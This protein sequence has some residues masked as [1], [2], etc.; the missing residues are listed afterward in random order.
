M[1]PV[2][3]VSAPSPEQVCA[4]WAEAFAPPHEGHE[5][6]L[7]T[8]L[9]GLP[10]IAAGRVHDEAGQA[11]TLAQVAERAADHEPAAR[12]EAEVRRGAERRPFLAELARR[13]LALGHLREPYPEEDHLLCPRRTRIDPACA[14][15]PLALARAV[16]AVELQQAELLAE[17]TARHLRWHAH[18]GGQEPAL[19]WLGA[20]LQDDTAQ[21]LLVTA[22]AAGQ[23]G[24]DGHEAKELFRLLVAHYEAC[25]ERAGGS[26]PEWPAGPLTAGCAL[27]L[28]L[29]RPREA[30]LLAEF[31]GHV[32]G[33]PGWQD[34]GRWPTRHPGTDLADLKAR[35]TDRAAAALGLGQRKPWPRAA[36]A[37]QVETCWPPLLAF[38]S[39]AP[40][41]PAR[42]QRD[43]PHP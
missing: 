31:R 33:W 3:A 27:G 28:L 11:L 5:R 40:P 39:P 6:R 18:A 29:R 34:E 38:G 20:L 36:L 21:C 41:P 7:G 42:G 35:L 1:P 2:T 30:A 8:L 12:W 9:D 24:P 22:L 10:L 14:D 16:T 17:V 26:P 32:E 4:A 25:R 13:V 23:P 37:A 15:A 19:P 43:E